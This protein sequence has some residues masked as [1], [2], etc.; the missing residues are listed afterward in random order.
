[1][2]K[3]YL[4]SKDMSI[5]ALAKDSG[6]PYSTLN[7]L[8]NGKVAI[9]KCRV[10]VLK[11]LSDALGLSMDEMYEVC[12]GSERVIRNSYG[13]DVRMYVRAKY[14]Y[15]SFM[16][17]EEPVELELCGVSEDS[18]FYIEEIARWRSEGYIRR[19]RIQEWW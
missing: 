5:Y 3:E 15:A 11:S 6:I 17:K 13:V 12:S 9:E 10:S 2:L 7:D 18:S 4:K 8:A 19:R 1:M 14:Y 16:Y